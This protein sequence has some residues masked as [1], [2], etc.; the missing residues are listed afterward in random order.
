MHGAVVT[1]AN[2]AEGVGDQKGLALKNRLSAEPVQIGPPGILTGL[3][4]GAKPHT[5]A[6]H[7]VI[8]VGGVE[9]ANDGDGRSA[10]VADE[11]GDVL[12]AG[13]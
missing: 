1:Q 10:E 13:P 8:R 2:V 9:Q 5:G 11:R 7:P 4:P 3:R 12:A 6:D